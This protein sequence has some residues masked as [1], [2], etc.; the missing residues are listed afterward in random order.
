MNQRH[1][2]KALKYAPLGA[3]SFWA[4]SVFLHW[5]RGYRFSGSDVIGLTVLLPITTGMVVSID[6]KRCLK[7][8]NRLPAALFALLGIWLFGPLMM[9]VGATFSGGGFSQ[10]EGWRFV[11]VGTGFFPIF[12]FIGSTYDGTL[13]ALL[14]TTATLPFLSPLCSFI[15]RRLREGAVVPNPPVNRR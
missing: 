9:S 4:P 1:I 14:L 2:F 15:H 7:T 8:E 13:G 3:F 12:T 5:L 10:P 11:L 6:A